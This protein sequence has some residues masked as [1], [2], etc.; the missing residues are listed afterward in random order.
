MAFD[1]PY[2]PVHPSIWCYCAPGKYL[3]GAATSGCTNC[4]DWFAGQV[5]G[6]RYSLRELDQMAEA[7]G[8]DTPVFLPF[9]FGERCPGWHDSRLGGFLGVKGSHSPGQLYRAILEGALF[10]L[11][12]CY[13]VLTREA[14]SPRE[15]RASGG[16][17]KSPLWLQMLAD[18]FGREITVH[19]SE[20]ASML[21]AA[22]LGLTALGA[23]DS[24]ERFPVGEGK[25]I[26]PNPEN[27]VL[28]QE[29]YARYR[30][31]YARVL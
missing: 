24:P 21:G 29:K 15:I 10:N 12:Q 18:I 23:M 9:L 3:A 30:E 31:S 7:S 22:A 13:E 8:P 2:L 28:Y 26:C 20:Q 14:Y 27:R 17:M 6:G 11:Y 5:L 25:V 19:P 1:R 4:L 16:V